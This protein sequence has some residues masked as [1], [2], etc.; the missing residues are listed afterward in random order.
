MIGHNG[1]DKGVATVAFLDPAEDIGVVALANAG[2]RRAAGR[3]PLQQIM[4]LLFDRTPS[5]K[6]SPG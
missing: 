2:W 3:W 4:N 6:T 5:L 1:G